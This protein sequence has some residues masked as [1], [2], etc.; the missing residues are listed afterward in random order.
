MPC[1]MTQE[2][3]SMA[4]KGANAFKDGIDIRALMVP[5]HSAA[6]AQRGGAENIGA[7]KKE[8]AALGAGDKAVQIVR[9][10]RTK[11]QKLSFLDG[12]AEKLRTS[13]IPDVSVMGLQGQRERA[14]A[15]AGGFSGVSLPDM[16]AG[17]F[18]AHLAR[19]YSFP[20][21]PIITMLTDMKS[22]R[23]D[24]ETDEDEVETE[25]FETRCKSA[26]LEQLNKHRPALE[27]AARKSLKEYIS[28]RP[29]QSPAQD[30]AA[31]TQWRA[32]VL[33]T[34]QEE[35]AKR[36]ELVTDR[37]LRDRA[38]H[39][40][41]AAG[42]FGLFA[43]GVLLAEA[44]RQAEQHYGES[45]LAK[46]ASVG[47][48]TE[49][50]G[51]LQLP[52]EIHWDAEEDHDHVAVPPLP[53]STGRSRHF[54]G[55]FKLEAILNPIQFVEEH[56]KKLKA[57]APTEE[58]AGDASDYSNVWPK[59]S[60]ILQE[61]E[62]GTRSAGA[63]AKKLWA[64]PFE[65]A[66]E[67]IGRLAAICRAVQQY[68]NAEQHA[69]NLKALKTK[70][71]AV[72]YFSQKSV[73]ADFRDGDKDSVQKLAKDITD[74]RVSV[75]QVPPLRCVLVREGGLVKVGDE[76]Q[77]WLSNWDSA[78]HPNCSRRIFTLDNRRLHAFKLAQE[79]EPSEAELLIPI[80]LL[81]SAALAKLP[82]AELAEHRERFS[83]PDGGKG[84]KLLGTPG[85]Y[86]QRKRKGVWSYRL[87]VE[88]KQVGE[89]LGSGFGMIRP[90]LAAVASPK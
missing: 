34:L 23:E 50:D 20:P 85:R 27:K 74:G 84:I 58:D 60:E 43:G 24:A 73:S 77:K 11:A 75:W 41:I 30:A 3:A 4:H 14:A 32:S 69:T 63:L 78:L 48:G 25:D 56:V 35:H 64:A 15:G 12:T 6:N 90:A 53:S 21:L 29:R 5:K 7:M 65:I 68:E 31:W 42:A 89:G 33:P 55:K 17:D 19:A 10:L 57:K 26:V 52:D 22:E 72:V 67:P 88:E 38:G 36:V 87:E 61:H 80:V 18:A 59:I 79:M 51:L 66:L 81:N 2:L 37:L 70:P 47:A 44:Y 83:T 39:T 76:Q 86:V 82:A 49:S 8:P 28:K 62:E 1:I 16:L 13:G 9:R 71:V 45:T 40:T 54:A 46:L